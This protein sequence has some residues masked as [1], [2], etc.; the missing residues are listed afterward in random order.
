MKIPASELPLQPSGAIYHIDIHPDNLADKI[1]LVGDPGRVPT[2]SAKF[3]S[4]EL[5]HSNREMT[6]HTGYYKN[7]RISVVSTGMGT[8]TIDI[9]MNELDALA[10]IDLQ[11]MEHKTE[12][13]T[14]TIVR[15]GTCGILQE[16]IPAGT[17][18]AA[19]HG[20]G[21][22]G[23]LQFYKHNSSEYEDF[24]AHFVEFTGWNERLPY[25]YCFSADPTLFETIAFDMVPGITA[26]AP[27]F[28][29]HKAE[30]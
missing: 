2:I 29:V 23:L 19:K 24:V 27:G 10:N 11:K 3:D 9:V 14:L 7:K 12:H 26:S 4:I 5:T 22:D 30:L 17:V 21:F 15:I 25:P 18:I 13:K 28:L 8:D 1:V 16:T 6:T 20:F